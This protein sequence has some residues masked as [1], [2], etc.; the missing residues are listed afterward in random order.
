MDRWSW[1]WNLWEAQHSVT[2]YPFYLLIL[3]NLFSFLFFSTKKTRV[4]KNVLFL[5]RRF[6][7]WFRAEP[8]RRRL[9]RA[10]ERAKGRLK[11]DKAHLEIVS[12]DQQGQKRWGQKENDGSVFSF[13]FFFIVKDVPHLFVDDRFELSCH[14]LFCRNGTGRRRGRRRRF[15][16]S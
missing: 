10:R 5:S 2:G 11:A 3:P 7:G 1:G 15:G 8:L 6:Q 9:S 4:R 14:F 16:A 13:L 12:I